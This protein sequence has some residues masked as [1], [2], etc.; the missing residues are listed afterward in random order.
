MNEDFESFYDKCL[1]DD[2]LFIEWEQYKEKKKKR[3]KIATLFIIIIDS[4]ILLLLIKKFI[5]FGLFTFVLIPALFTCFII[6]IIIMGISNIGLNNQYNNL[7]KEKV[8]D[9]L[10]KN[11]FNDVDYIP[12]KQMPHE[13]YKEPKYEGYY[14]EYNSDDYMDGM[15]DEKYQIKMTDI[16]TVDVETSTDSDGH[17]TT[18][19]TTVF[20]GLFA[21]INIEKSIQNELRIKQNRT[22]FK[23][24][25]LEMDSEEFEKYFD[26][27][28]INQIIGMQILTHDI[29]D[30]LIEY[31]IKLERPFDI[32][33]KDNIMYIRLHIG[34][35][36]EV[37]FNKNEFIDKESLK[38]YYEM[39]KFIYELSKEMIKVVEDTEI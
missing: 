4:I 23:K 13:I 17:T 6:D 19:R 29:M 8:I 9:N 30:L 37:K 22:I 28:S 1:Q 38:K 32:V 10:L 25:K 12:K 14:N 7:Y 39:V 35:M 26:V 11:F 15:I 24:N 18:T 27:S 16:K 36:F 34:S 31:R 20:S 2:D 21:K 5:D 3:V 33:I